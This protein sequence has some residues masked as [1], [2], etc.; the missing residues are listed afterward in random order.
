[1]D[2]KSVVSL[3]DLLGVSKRFVDFFHDLGSLCPRK[4]LPARRFFEKFGSIR[5][6]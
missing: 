6:M 4:E 1:M 3:F 5:Q 2:P